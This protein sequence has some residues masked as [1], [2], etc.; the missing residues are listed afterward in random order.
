MG[1]ILYSANPIQALQGSLVTVAI[2]LGIGIAG[3]GYA[4]LNQGV[5]RLGRLAAG[6]AGG[7]LVIVGLIYAGLTLFSYLRGGQ[8]VSVLLYDKQVAQDNC[9][10]GDTCTRYVLETSANNVYYDF[11]VPPDVYDAAQTDDCYQI[12]YYG[13]Q[14]PF[15]VAQDSQSY[16]Q[17]DAVTRIQLADPSVCR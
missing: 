3:L 2:L 13:S 10:N 5:G 7:F 4:V 8:T 9:N 14:S 12:T 11:N 6:F 17:I 16:H 15:N 1:P